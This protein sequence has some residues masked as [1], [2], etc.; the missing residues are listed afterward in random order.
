MAT[1]VLQNSAQQ[2][3]AAVTAAYSGLVLGGTGLARITGNQTISGVKTFANQAV[4]SSG[5]ILNGPTQ[6]NNIGAI[7]PT[8]NAIID[9]GSASNQ[10]K[11]GWFSGIS[12]TNAIIKNLIVSDSFT[13]PIIGL[14]LINSTGISVTLSGTTNLNSANFSGNINSAGTNTFSGNLNVS[15]NSVFNGTI[16]ATGSKTFSGTLSQTG[17]FTLF[18][19]LNHSGDFVSTGSFSHSGVLTNSGDV[20]FVG[21]LSS[22]G[23]VT[24]NGDGNKNFQFTGNGANFTVSGASFNVNAAL[25]LTGDL[26]VTGNQ[27]NFVGTIFHTG[28]VNDSGQFIHVGE[29]RNTGALTN[30]GL[31]NLNGRVS[32]PSGITFS[33]N[34][35][36]PAITLQ[37]NLVNLADPSGGAIEYGANGQFY[38]TNET[39]GYTNRTVLNPIYSFF[40]P[41]Q[42]FVGGLSSGANTLPLGDTGVYLNTGTYHITYNARFKKG[43][44]DRTV[45]M[46]ITGGELSNFTNRFGSIS[47][48]NLTD[49]SNAGFSFNITGI[50]PTAAV[51]TSGTSGKNESLTIDGSI[52]SRSLGYFQ[53][54]CVVSVTALTKVRPFIRCI[55][56]LAFPGES[57]TGSQ[58][59]MRVTPLSTGIGSGL[60]SASGPWTAA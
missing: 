5:A 31:T 15:G 7:T 44:P 25:N 48:R 4:F 51:F 30:V 2:I 23:N 24:F 32:A 11:T 21:D 37:K 13:A 56:S 40:L 22:K 60:A 47:K 50:T 27:H 33:G 3:D 52:D 20:N 39:A 10:F 57:I 58:F 45:I 18:G 55:D 17:N 59:V 14:Q 42:Y 26:F 34:P 54:D 9:L 46:G 19:G 12:G 36:T 53:F 16:T 49:T 8:G 6:L 29:V 1:Y 28:N 35:Y 38:F 41:S 43:F